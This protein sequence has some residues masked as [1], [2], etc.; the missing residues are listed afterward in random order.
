MD[1]LDARLVFFGHSLP[2]LNGG[3]DALPDYLSRQVRR[4]SVGMS[5]SGNASRLG[6]ESN[7]RMIGVT[8]LF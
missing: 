4:D 5:S 8:G 7:I 1:I 6:H 3:P 2:V